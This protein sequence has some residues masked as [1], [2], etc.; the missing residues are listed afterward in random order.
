MEPG[1]GKT[2]H[3]CNGYVFISHMMKT[4]TKG[5]GRV[6]VVVPNGVLFRC[7][8]EEKISYL[9]PRE[10]IRENDYNLKISRYVDTFEE[11]GIDIAAVQEKIVGIEQGLAHVREQMA[12]CLKELGL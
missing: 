4:T 8:A 5:T 6:G 11:E 2:C 1:A 12:A 9:A 3:V 7:G 10:E